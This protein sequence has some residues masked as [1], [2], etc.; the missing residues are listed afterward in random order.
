[1]EPC[2][3]IT[4]T[5]FTCWDEGSMIPIFDWRKRLQFNWDRAMSWHS[6]IRTQTASLANS[7]LDSCLPIPELSEYRRCRIFYLSMWVWALFT[8]WQTFQKVNIF[9]YRLQKLSMVGCKR[10]PLT[11]VYELTED[12]WRNWKIQSGTLL[13]DWMLRRCMSYESTKVSEQWYPMAISISLMRYV[14]FTD[15]VHIQAIS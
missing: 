15:C 10:T 4:I 9:F 12:F 1:M 5:D 13:L 8:A 6:V 11:I 2:M 3:K 14:V 7:Y